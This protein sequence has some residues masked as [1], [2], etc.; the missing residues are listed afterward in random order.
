MQGR[1]CSRGSAWIGLYLRKG[2]KT[3]RTV[4]EIIQIDTYKTTQLC[5]LMSLFLLIEKIGQKEIFFFRRKPYQK[6]WNFRHF[7]FWSILLPKFFVLVE[8]FR[9][10]RQKMSIEKIFLKVIFWSR[11]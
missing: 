7:P 2:I 11:S 4:F 9:T 1:I 8:N 3:P 10:G 6:H 5:F